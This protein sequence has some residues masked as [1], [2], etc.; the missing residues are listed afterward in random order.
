[1]VCQVQEVTAG[2]SPLS[3]TFSLI[4]PGYNFQEAAETG[5]IPVRA[6]AGTLAS[7][8]AKLDLLTKDDIRVSR[9]SPSAEGELAW[10]VT[11]VSGWGDVPAMQA[12]SN[13]VT[14]TDATVRVATMAN[15]VA[16]IKGSLSLVVS[17]VRGQVRRV[18]GILSLVVFVARFEID[19]TGS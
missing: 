14:G 11:F 9:S 5:P 18:H 17:G 13:G 19:N 1:M 12:V 3:G 8:L 10:T 2:S 15:G 16:P 7:E 4:Y 6:S